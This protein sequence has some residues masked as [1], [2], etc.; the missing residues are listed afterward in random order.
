MNHV[1]AIRVS[2]MIC[3]IA[4]SLSAFIDLGLWFY[5]GFLVPSW[6]ISGLS[7]VISFFAYVILKLMGDV[8]K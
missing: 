5:S 8:E 4:C 2:L 6:A 1:K 7:M 3:I